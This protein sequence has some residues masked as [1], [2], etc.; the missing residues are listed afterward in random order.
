MMQG[1]ERQ[2]EEMLPL[3][4]CKRI[5]VSSKWRQTLAR[6]LSGIFMLKPVRAPVLYRQATLRDY[7]QNLRRL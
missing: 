5:L 1:R 4:T 7:A 2:V 6:P 3:H